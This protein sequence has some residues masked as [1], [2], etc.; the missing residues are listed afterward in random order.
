VIF[1]GVGKRADEIRRALQVGIRC[2]NVESEPELERIAA[3][4]AELGLHRAGLA[5]G[6]SGRGR[7]LAS[8]HLH[9]PA[10]EQV[11]HRH[12]R[13]EA[14]YRAPRPC[15]TCAWSASTAISARN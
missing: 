7:P 3:V 14:V 10:R 15:R 8:V 2:F 11:R 12:P 1:S 4:A 9:R 13:A 5:A 6:Q